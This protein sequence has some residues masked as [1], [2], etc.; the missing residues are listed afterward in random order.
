MA[1]GFTTLISWHRWKST[2]S[3]TLGIALR[4]AGIAGRQAFIILSVYSASMGA[5]KGMFIA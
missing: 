1:T 3:L 4:A 2:I 5:W